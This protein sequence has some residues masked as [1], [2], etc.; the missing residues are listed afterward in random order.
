MSTTTFPNG[1]LVREFSKSETYLI[2]YG[3][4]MLVYDNKIGMYLVKAMNLDLNRVRNVP[5]GSLSSIPIIKLKT[6]Y[7]FITPPSLVFPPDNQGGKIF[8]D[9]PG[10]IKLKT[11]DKEIRIR[12]FRGWLRAIDGSCNVKDPDWHYYLDIDPE[13][14]DTNGIDLNQIL[15]VGNIIKVDFLVRK[16]NDKRTG[17]PRAILAHPCI[18]V[19]LN[20]WRAKSAELIKYN[21]QFDDIIKYPPWEPNRRLFFTLVPKPSD[22][23]KQVDNV[24]LVDDKWPTSFGTVW[25]YDPFINDPK[26]ENEKSLTPGI[27]D[28]NQ[29]APY[30]SI[31]GSILTD[32]PH[33]SEGFV[34]TF[35]ARHFD[36]DPTVDSGVRAAIEI[37]GANKDPKD[38]THPARW[39]EI[40]PPDVIKVH[41]YRKAKETLR[42]IAV[43][44][45]NGLVVGETR[46][47]SVDI[48]PPRPRPL[49]IS[50]LEVKELVGPETNY[51]TIIEGNATKSG[52]RLTTYS[53]R[54]NIYVKVQ[55]QGG[56][57]A[58]GKFKAIYR[59][60]WSPPPPPPQI[61][62]RFLYL[63]LLNRVPDDGG[64][65][66]YANLINNGTN[67]GAIVESFLRSLEYCNIVTNS[68]YNK[69]LE[70][71]SDP[72]GLQ[73]YSN[74]LSN[75]TP[76]QN[77][78]ISICDSPE[79]KNKYPVPY[80]FT[81]ALYNKILER[82]P[83]PGAVENTSLLHG[84][85]TTEYIRRFLTSSEYA[86]K[87]VTSYY[88]KYLG[89]AP[90]PE[91]DD[92]NREIARLLQNESLQQIIKGF[93]ISDEYLE[94]SNVR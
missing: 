67:I 52:A 40:H 80:E 23:W 77:V 28:Y 70:R 20:G 63:D 35:I 18:N 64:F 87:M 32:N 53:D 50:K 2:Y 93:L 86:S 88:N 61:W 19:E 81:R 51:R 57:G 69:Y 56:W 60:R 15:K 73:Y 48:Y 46:S 17:S 39:T 24:C 82:A 4:R 44:A 25:P 31:V 92:V 62:I 43:V 6:A 75:G 66:Y 89:R 79:F 5:D 59:V 9:V 34:G 58:P 12:E 42:G 37:W 55:G 83:E 33:V 21:S 76:I 54:V 13:W 84:V 91:W 1:T 38:P 3:N 27:Y 22:W 14:T 45:K 72:G 49:S 7:G 11:L 30:V 94:R 10:S 78:I 90:E 16:N 36:I 71:Q 26:K 68:L 85:T 41:D 47:I 65:N 74:M 8:L 29:N